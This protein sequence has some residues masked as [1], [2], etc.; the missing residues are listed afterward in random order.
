MGGNREAVRQLFQ[1]HLSSRAA[2]IPLD[3]INN[4]TINYVLESVEKWKN[5]KEK[6]SVNNQAPK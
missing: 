3:T 1:W 2:W 4:D 5:E 6:K